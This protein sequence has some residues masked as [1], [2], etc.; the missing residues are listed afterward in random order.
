MKFTVFNLKNDSL[1]T[2][3]KQE[4]MRFIKREKLNRRYITI[5]K[6]SDTPSPHYTIPVTEESLPKKDF[7]RRTF[8]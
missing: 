8:F 7:F 2:G 4:C 1:F 5:E 3:T 6:Q